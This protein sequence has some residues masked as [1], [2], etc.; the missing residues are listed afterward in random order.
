[1]GKFLALVILVVTTVWL[2][3]LCARL[4]ETASTVAAPVAPAPPAPPAPA[5]VSS[6]APAPAPAAKPEPKPAAKPRPAKGDVGLSTFSMRSMFPEEKEKYVV[7]V[8]RANRSAEAASGVRMTLTARKD[9]AILERAESGPGQ[10]LAAGTSSYFGLGISTMI[11]DELLDAPYGDGTGL[12]W[13]LVYR[14]ASDA[15]GATRCF[16]LYA[17]P[18]RREPAGIDWVPQ[19][20]SRSCAP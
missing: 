16:R 8:V 9:G 4:P 17:L 7:S 14:L 15:P 1:M 2:A 19:G 10:T 20:E 13:S 3:P 12:E 18:R 5:P 6:Q 11:L